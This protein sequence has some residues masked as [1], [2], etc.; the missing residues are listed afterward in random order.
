MIQ[1]HKETIRD[2]PLLHVVGGSAQNEALPLI[3]FLHGFTSAKEHNLHYAY[4]L[5]EKGFRVVLPDAHF[6]GERIQGLNQRELSFYFWKIVIQN[7][8]ELGILKDS[9]VNDGLADENRIGVVGTSMGAITTLGAISQ[10]DWIN[11]GVSL[12]GNGA[13]ETFARSQIDYL[14][15]NHVAIPLSEQELEHQFSILAQYDLSQQM[16]KLNGRPLLFWHGKKDPIV[17]FGPAY[18]FYEAISKYYVGKED[19][20]QFIVDEKA[21]HKVTRHGLLKT[22]EWFEEHM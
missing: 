9:F 13:Y 22:V 3:F 1:I 14:R 7:I 16:E 6:H 21:D 20:L 5:A 8:E 10:Y 4:L 15:Q 11:T 12:M 18:D 17:P 2:I 19:K